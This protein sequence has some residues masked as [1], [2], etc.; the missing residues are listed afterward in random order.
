MQSIEDPASIALLRTLKRRRGG[1]DEL[2]ACRECGQWRAVRSDEIND[3]LKRK[4][5]DDF[6]AK[7]FRTWNATVM[8]AVALAADGHEARTKAAR[9]RAMDHAIRQVSELL[10]NTPAVARRAYIDPR[11]FDRYL[12]GWTIASAVSEAAELPADDRA[13]QKIE[14]AVVDLLTENTDS[15]ALDRAPSSARVG[16]L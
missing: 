7:D 5:G 15:D 6:S 9:K 16:L 13:R 2:L 14:S 8:A 4:L 10:G 12:S 11:V 1:P 3:Y